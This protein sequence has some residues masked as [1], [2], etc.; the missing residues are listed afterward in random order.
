MC[1]VDKFSRDK[2]KALNLL[3]YVL[4]IVT[5]LYS[6][7]ILWFHFSFYHQLLVLKVISK[8]LNTLEAFLCWVR[9]NNLKVEDTMQCM[10]W[11]N[12]LPD[13]TYCFGFSNLYVNYLFLFT[14]SM[15]LGFIQTFCSF[16]F[17]VLIHK[18]QAVERHAVLSIDSYHWVDSAELQIHSIHLFW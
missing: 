17:F 9:T 10:G 1:L 5:L 2:A 16:V 3:K 7:Y 18:N 14:T 11:N 8:E 15:L 4:Q 13:C 6:S 12:V